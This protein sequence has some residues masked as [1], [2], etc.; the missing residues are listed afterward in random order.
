MTNKLN[1]V[2]FSDEIYP[3]ELQNKEDLLDGKATLR[4]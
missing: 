3:R 4:E 1:D 2:L